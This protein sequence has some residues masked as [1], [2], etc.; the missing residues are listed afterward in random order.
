[1]NT[2]KLCLHAGASE[3]ERQ[4]LTTIVLPEET[5]SYCPVGHAP[6][7]DLVEDQMREVGF[8]FGTEAHSL[9]KDGARYFGI[10]QLLNGIDMASEQ[11]ALVMGLRNSYD[12]SFPAA[13]AFGSHVFVCDNLAFTGEVTISRRH[14]VNV[15]RDLPAL[16]TSAVSQTKVMAHNQTLRFEHYQESK[17]KGNIAD[18]LIVEMLR[19]GIVNTSRVEKVVKEWDEPSHDFGGRTAWRLFNAAT[20]ALKGSPLP[21]MP[22][23]TI[24]LQALLDQVTDFVPTIIDGEAVR[25]H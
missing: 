6:L 16:I 20:E 15:W 21:Q 24:T 25:V 4:M 1:M 14:T 10:I 22:Q 11:H 3:V 5:K 7:L 9:T 13:L 19:Q 8:R 12:K 23:R 2:P 17:I 18:H